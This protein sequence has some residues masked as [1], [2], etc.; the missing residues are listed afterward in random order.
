MTFAL[1]TNER[2][3]LLEAESKF[4]LWCC[5]ERQFASV[6]VERYP[7][8]PEPRR[9]S[10]GNHIGHVWV[11]IAAQQWLDDVHCVPAQV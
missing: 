10:P 7:P 4:R 3:L 2:E 8:L 9:G 5:T 11:R 6:A 1:S